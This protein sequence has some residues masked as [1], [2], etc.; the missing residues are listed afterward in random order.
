M[1][2]IVVGNSASY[3]STTANASTIATNLGSRHA[4]ASSGA[5]TL[6]N[7]VSWNN[8]DANNP[9]VARDGSTTLGVVGGAN[10]INLE[11]LMPN[12]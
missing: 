12:K 6:K 4:S 8:S 5:L 11:R 7:G 9:I 2:S 3:G 1:T 10:V